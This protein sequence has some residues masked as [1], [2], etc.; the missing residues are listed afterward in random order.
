LRYG[1]GYFEEDQLGHVGDVGLWRRISAYS[2]PYRWKLS[3][4]I[5]LSLA[6]IG[7]SLAL[8]HMV[9]LGVDN[10]IVNAALDTDERIS[11]LGTLAS[12]FIGVVIIGFIANFLQVIILE[13]TGQTIMHNLRQ[14]LF[15]HM[16][17]LD[18]AFFNNNPSGKLV[19]RLTNDIQNMY[20]MFTSVIVTL[21]ND[22]I[23]LIG[24]MAILFYMNWRLALILSLLVPLIT[25]NTLWFSRLARDAFRT[26]RT[27][28]AR[29]N[30]YVQE[31]ISGISVIQL[32]LRER[33]TFTRFTELNTAYLRRNLYQIKIF[34]IFMPAIELFSAIA[35]G[36]IIWYG[37]GQIIQQNMTIGELSAFIA[38]MRLFFQPIREL[39]QK[40]SIVQ[41]AM[42]SAE[43]IFQLLDTKATLTSAKIKEKQP[44]VSGA[45]TFKQVS[46]GYE[47]DQKVLCDLSFTVRPGQTLAIVGA[48][49]SGKST[50]VNLLERFY[51]PGQGE[52]L[53]DGQDICSLNTTWLRQQ[54]GLVLQ[55]VFIVPGSIR[56]NIL[57]DTDMED[58]ALWTVAEKA[59]LTGLIE[60]LPEGLETIIGEG[61][62][63]LS[64]GQK[65]LLTFARVLARD[66]KILVL[67]EATSSVDSAT[68]IL[69]DRAIATTLANRTSIVIAHR[70]STIRR[71]DHILVMDQGRI[72]EQGSH[73]TLL[74]KKGLYHRLQNLQVKMDQGVKISL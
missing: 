18:I 25:L 38:Y 59:Q 28:I 70:L 30:A 74:G 14:Q 57:L 65:Q 39:S 67:D 1:Y 31:S 64:S 26:I 32:F 6:I 24:I 63:N 13:W 68:E 51:D 45:I 15:S 50:I 9:R 22:S 56:E 69:I 58:A 47:K 27:H 61:G 36:C 43:R 53:I 48:T 35:I 11:G 7:S 66:P 52:I 33:D 4:A 40:Y 44:Q 62:M 8:P 34:A 19:T 23:K 20:E 41:S 60:Q 16:A 72:V 55:D 42:A 71:A 2:W 21:F 54:I 3:V 5:L 29:I 37:G 49:G 12:I 73:E 17:S 10:Y 46:F